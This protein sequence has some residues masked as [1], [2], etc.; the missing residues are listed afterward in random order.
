MYFNDKNATTLM[1]AVKGHKVD[2]AQIRYNSLCINELS[3]V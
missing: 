2:W 3:I 1:R